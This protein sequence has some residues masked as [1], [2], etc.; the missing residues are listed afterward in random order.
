MNFTHKRN[1]SL[2][3]NT[4]LCPWLILVQ[5]SGI[6]DAKNFSKSNYNKNYKA[7]AGKPLLNALIL[8]RYKARI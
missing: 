3:D 8:V 6:C 4:A 2:L 1:Q 5:T 7:G